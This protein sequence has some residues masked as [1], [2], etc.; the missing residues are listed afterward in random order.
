MS[1]P[2]GELHVDKESSP[3]IFVEAWDL[4]RRTDEFLR[5]LEAN[6]EPADSH[7]FVFVDFEN[8]R[9]LQDELEQFEQHLES[10]LKWVWGHRLLVNEFDQLLH[11]LKQ[12][13]PLDWLPHED[14]ISVEEVLVEEETLEELF[15]RLPTI[16]KHL[17]RI[18]KVLESNIGHNRFPQEIAKTKAEIQ[19]AKSLISRLK[20]IEPSSVSDSEEAIIRKFA[21]LCISIGGAWM[22][23]LGKKADGLIEGFISTAGPEAGKWTARGLAVFLAGSGVKD[24]GELLLKALH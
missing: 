15:E 18:S 19:S 11:R 5:W 8:E 24:F 16:E 20:E 12:K 10:I 9:E 14:R 13:V 22:R 4:E 21:K 3:P 6:F 2:I 1:E 23:Y 7:Y 17:E